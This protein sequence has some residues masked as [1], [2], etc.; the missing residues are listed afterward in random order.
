MAITVVGLGTFWSLIWHADVHAFFPYLTAGLLVWNFIVAGLVEGSV[1]FAQQASVIRAAP[2]PLFLHPLRMSVRLTITLLHNALVYVGVAL[3]FGIPLT[4]AS[5]LVVPGLAILFA[6]AVASGLFFGIVGARFRDFS[7]IMESV[8][9][10]MFF[11]T[12]VL[13]FRSALGP[14]AYLAD[15]NPFTH[16][17]AI[18]REPMLGNVPPLHS[19]VVAASLVAVLGGLGIAVFAKWRSKIS[20]WV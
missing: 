12:P 10:L 9:P 2:L 15:L 11:I 4:P 18:V 8:V 16:L 19:Y 6:F 3:F 7:P 5:F 14:R 20:L 17:I 1:C 13:W